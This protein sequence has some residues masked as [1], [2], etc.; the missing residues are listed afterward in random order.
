MRG[1][2]DRLAPRFLFY[3]SQNLNFHNPIGSLWYI[4]KHYDMKTKL[5]S[6]LALPAVMSLLSFG[7]FAATPGVTFLFSN[8]Q[9]ATF[10]FTSK[11][12]I[13]VTSDGL[14]ISSSNTSAVSY[15]FADVQKFYFEDDITTGIPQVEGATSAHRPV[16]NYVNG[17]VTVCGL[18]IGERF[19]A[20]ALNGS[21]I[22]TVKADA[23]G[24]ASID[25]SSVPAGVYVVCTGN[26]V[27]FKL[28]KK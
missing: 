1:T 26:G 3:V 23:Q 18:A 25:L 27:S 20:F 4:V 6:R 2:G 24:N 21:Q 14:T 15:S 28:L 12:E 17:I 7:C 8:G 11:P 19:A 9:K 16:F 5:F 22:G 10:A 13:S